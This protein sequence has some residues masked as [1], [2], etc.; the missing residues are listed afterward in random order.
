[1]SVRVGRVG[2]PL[3]CPWASRLKEAQDVGREW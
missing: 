1:M 2:Y 3:K